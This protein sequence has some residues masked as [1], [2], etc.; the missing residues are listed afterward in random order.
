ML[1]QFPDDFSGFRQVKMP[2]KIIDSLRKRKDLRLLVELQMQLLIRKFFNFIEYFFQVLLIFVDE[3]KVIHVSRIVFDAISFL[4]QPVDRIKIL[5][6]KPLT[7]L[8]AER[9]AFAS[10]CVMTVDDHIQQIPHSFIW[11]VFQ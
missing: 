10:I 2:S 3:H 5:Q 11:V 4:D 1:P 9:Q 8:L 6:R 7:G